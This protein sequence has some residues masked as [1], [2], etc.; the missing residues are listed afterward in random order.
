MSDQQGF[1][2]DPQRHN[3]PP[4]VIPLRDGLAPP[5]RPAPPPPPPRPTPPAE[6]AQQRLFSEP[7]RDVNP[8]YIQMARA[9]SQILATRFLLLLAVLTASGVWAYCVYDPT[10]LRI[11]ASGVYSGLCLWPLTWLYWKKG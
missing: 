6:A 7:I 3:Q 4:P 8:A 11:V 10:Q 9:V 1:Q 2:F 5:P